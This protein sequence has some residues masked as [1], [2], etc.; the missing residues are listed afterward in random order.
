MGGPQG[1]DVSEQ[2][3][4]GWRQALQEAGLPDLHQSLL[5][6][7]DFTSHGGYTAMQTV[8]KL[9]PQPSAIFVCNDLMAIGA[10]SAA[11][12]V[13]LRVPSALSV[14]GFDDIELASYSCPPLTTVAQPKQ[15]IGV[16]AVD[17]LLERIMGGR[18]Q[19]RKVLLQ[20]ELRVRSSSGPCPK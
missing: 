7:G 5:V 14:V 18:T 2:R 11:H 1:L 15:R 17:M 19:P 3:I 10:L 4:Q 20:P 16:L 6:H 12:E 8:L 9:Q 13:H